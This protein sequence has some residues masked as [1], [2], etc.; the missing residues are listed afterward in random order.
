MA[1]SIKKMLGKKPVRVT[2]TY[3]LDPIVVQKIDDYSS[4]ENAPSASELV[5]RILREKL[6]LPPNGN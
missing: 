3:S 4:D 5:N 1:E 2:R 6:G